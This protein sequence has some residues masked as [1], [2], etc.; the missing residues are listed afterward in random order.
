[1]TDVFTG[2][3][4]DVRDGIYSERAMW[5]HSRKV[6]YKARRDATLETKL[7]TGLGPQASRSVERYTYVL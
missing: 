2:R 3:E 5:K 7:I 1:M 6:D 4:R